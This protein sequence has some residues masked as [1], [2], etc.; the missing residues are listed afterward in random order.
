MDITDVYPVNS[1]GKWTWTSLLQ[2]LLAAQPLGSAETHQVLPGRGAPQLAGSLLTSSLG[3][4]T[5]TS[6]TFASFL[7][8]SYRL[9]FF[10]SRFSG[11]QQDWSEASWV[12]FSSFSFSLHVCP[13]P[14]LF[15][16]PWALVLPS[17]EV[18]LK[19][20]YNFKKF[21]VEKLR[22]MI[23]S[24]GHSPGLCAKHSQLQEHQARP[25]H[26]LSW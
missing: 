4:W 16:N 5:L 25:S 10:W 19:L 18:M 11:S 1:R 17:G 8:P 20:A 22:P 21:V 13:F 24:R 3:S 12:T 15:S 6:C 14:S 9:F 23:V 2:Q 26:V 7:I